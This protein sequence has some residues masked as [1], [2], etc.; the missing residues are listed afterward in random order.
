MSMTQQALRSDSLHLIP[1]PWTYNPSKWSQRAGI[2]V[3]AAAAFLIA[4]YM[5]MYQ[6]G[7]IDE[8]WDPVFGAQSAAVLDSDVSHTMYRYMRIPDSVLGSFAYLAD[9]I[10]VLA[11]STR[12]WQYRPWLVMMFAVCLIPLGIVSVILV[13][14]QGLVIGSWCFLCLCTAAL[15]LLM[16]YR[17]YDEVWSTWLYLWRTYKRSGSKKMLWD[18][19][20]GR[21]SNV[22]QAVA[23]DLVR[24][25]PA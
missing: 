15:S 8:V 14:I 7:L 24:R 5:G 17:G 25:S 20:W 10:L 3:M 2:A 6:W 18:T 9:L 13:G 22:A 4:A 21:P 1:E 11:G 16:I 19:F 23:M 12:R